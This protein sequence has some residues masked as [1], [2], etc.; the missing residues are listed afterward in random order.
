M[1]I[2]KLRSAA[3]ANCYISSWRVCTT[4][5]TIFQGDDSGYNN[6][7][8]PDV[9]QQCFLFNPKVNDILFYVGFH[10]FP[11]TVEILKRTSCSHTVKLELS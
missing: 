4:H 6:S 3:K 2:T 10:F 1:V 11:H 7:W 5:H 9:F 8:S